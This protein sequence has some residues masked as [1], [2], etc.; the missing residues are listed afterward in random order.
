[1]LCFEFYR[2]ISQRGIFIF[3]ER[4]KEREDA[5]ALKHDKA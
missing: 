3:L 1:M 4:E 2:K 5:R